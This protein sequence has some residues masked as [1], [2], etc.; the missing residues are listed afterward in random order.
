MDSSGG[1]G[2][3]VEISGPADVR[4]LAEAELSELAAEIRRFLV[5]TVSARGGHLGPNLGVVELS[6]ALHR[7]FDSPTEPIVFDTGHQSY[8]HKI[9]TGR[10]ADFATLRARGGMS[11]YPARAESPHDVAESSHASMS[12]AYADGLAEV[13]RLEGRPAAVAAVIGDGALTGGPSWEGLNNLAARPGRR[14]VVVINDNGRSYSPTVGGITAGPNR[15]ARIAAA[16][17][18]DY[19]G[20]VDGHDIPALEEELRAAKA[21]GRVTLVH[22]LTGKGRGYAPAE[23]DESQRMHSVGPID[24]E[25]GEASGSPDDSGGRTWTAVFGESIASAAERDPSLVAV[26]AAMPGPTGLAPLA[27]RHPERV[28][29][30]GIAEAHA[31]AMAS[32]LSMHGIRPVVALYSTFLGRAVDQLLMDVAL[33]RSPVTIALDRAGITGPD[34]PSHHGIWDLALSAM[35]PGMRVAAPR[36]EP[37]MRAELDEALG[38]ERNALSA[39]L[40]RSEETGPQIVRYPKGRVGEPIP[41][42]ARVGGCDVLALA[43]AASQ[44]DVEDEPPRM[45]AESAIAGASVL[46]VSIGPMARPALDAARILGCG[47]E[48]VVVVDPRWVLPVRGEIVELAVAGPEVVAIIEDGIV[49][50]GVGDAVLHEISAGGLSPRPRVLTLGVPAEFV[51]HGGREELLAE[52]GLTGLALAERIGNALAEARGASGTG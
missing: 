40:D 11:G 27:E 32:G 24:P 1:T 46:I 31:L 39:E 12:L 33:L 49:A 18:L 25:S 34:G 43:E 8:V 7:V 2:R 5:E 51:P 19:R 29:D 17:G 47:G 52:L 14:V 3:V 48:R 50:G 4:A 30:V 16:L 21:T 9:L 45:T 37:S 13:I 38:S 22:V 41:A 10:A 20:P 36:D 35:V 44:T 26:T 6:I 23:A 28:I 15:A 42:L